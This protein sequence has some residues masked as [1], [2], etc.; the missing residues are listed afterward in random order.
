MRLY[1]WVCPGW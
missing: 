1:S